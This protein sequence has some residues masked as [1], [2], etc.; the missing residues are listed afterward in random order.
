M[1][2][3]RIR[4]NSKPITIYWSP[5][6]DPREKDWTFLYPY[7]ERLFDNL[8]DQKSKV[9]EKGSFLACPSFLDVTKNTLCVK[10]PISASYDVVINEKN[11][12]NIF[13]TSPEFFNT[14]TLRESPLDDAMTVFFSFHYI[15]FADEPLEIL[16]TSPY[17]HQSEYMKFG[18]LV[19]GSFDI[20]QWFRVL[21][22]EIQMWKNSKKFKIDK[23]EI[24]FYLYF[25]TDRPIVFKRFNYT[26]SLFK[27]SAS[28][29]TA[30]SVLGK[31]QTLVSRYFNFKNTGMRDKVLTLIK[32]NLIEESNPIKN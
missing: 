31:G 19:P 15:F 6:F 22:L 14:M 1:K 25:K 26:E 2:L 32:N 27:L 13:P 29:T 18:A 9:I 23:D 8:L 5:A 30:T 10:S 20:G 3:K 21:N 4:E 24:L 12:K 28:S 11:E 16:F 7:P 17:F